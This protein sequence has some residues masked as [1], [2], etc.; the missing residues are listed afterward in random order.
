MTKQLAILV[1]DG[2]E[3]LDAIGPYE[4]FATAAALRENFLNVYLVGESGDM[5]T[6]VNGL[7]LMPHHRF[8]DAPVPDV[9]IVPGGDGTRAE[10]H[11]HTVVDWVAGSEVHAELIASVCTGIRITLAA[12]VASNKRVTTHW[13][14]IEE[15]RARGEA[16][17]VLDGVRFV[18]DGD[19]VSSAGVSAGIDMA[20][21]LVGQW[22]D[23]ALARQVQT[24]IEYT[25]A[26]P[27]AFEVTSSRG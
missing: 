11:N 12:G 15:I 18:K 24:M 26:P 19:Y 14:A 7:T 8:E 27:Y 2:V 23:P 20:L 5:V 9:V 25:P 22:A 4:V 3:E 13:S 6:C 16:A 17:E 1:F 10:Q 21:W